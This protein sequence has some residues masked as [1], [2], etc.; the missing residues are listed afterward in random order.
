MNR[1]Q[2]SHVLRAASR[3]ANDPEVIVIGS[4]AILG[5]FKDTELPIETTRSI[6][7]DLAFRNDT[8]DRKSDLVDGSIGELSRFHQE[9]GYYPQGVSIATAVVP[10]GWYDRAVAYGEEASSPS[11]A[12][13]LDPHDL[14]VSKLVAGRQKDIEFMKALLKADLIS[15]DLL[16]ERAEM[17]DM[18]R[19][20]I[21]RVLS[22]IS[23]VSTSLN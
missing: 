10:L 13:C 1:E 2:L 20:V 14:V 7:A 18:P 15:V 12:I 17:L 4:Q 16:M 9:F 23:R 6:E 22:A 11:R 21:T 8:D 3:V 19:A 5:S